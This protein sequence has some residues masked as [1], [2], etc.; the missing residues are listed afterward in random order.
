MS[1]YI[2]LIVS[3]M[4][5]VS[6]KNSTPHIS[7]KSTTE[8]YFGKSII[9]SYRNLENLEDTIVL[10]YIKDYNK[11]STDQLSKIPNKERL[12]RLQNDFEKTKS[13]SYKDILYLK[14]YIFY[15]KRSV[16]ENEYKLYYK[17]PYENIKEVILFDPTNFELSKEQDFKITYFKPSWDCTKVLISLTKQGSEF[18]KMIVLDIKSNTVLPG[19]ITHSSPT[20]VGGVKWLP[21]NSGFVYNRFSDTLSNKGTYLN[22]KSVLYKLGEKTNKFKDLLS[23]DNNPELNINQ[24]E[25]PE[26]QIEENGKYAIGT[27]RAAGTY[28]ETYFL[29]IKDITTNNW[30]PLF[31]R[32]DKIRD[33][34]QIGDSLIYRTSKNSPNFKI[35]K[36]SFLNPDFEDPKVLVEE[37]KDRVIQ[38]YLIVNNQLFFTTIKNGVE[39]KMYSKKDDN[40]EVEI[41]LPFPSGKV[42]L[43]KTNNPNLLSVIIQGWTAPKVRYIYNTITGK[44]ELDKNYPASMKANFS[45]LIVE[46]VLVKSSDGEEIPLSLVYKKGLKK[47]S[48]T[49]VLMRAY[50]SYGISMT[51]NFYYGF[52]LWAQEGGIYAVAHVRGGGEKGDSWH[53]AGYKNTKSNSWKDL[54]SCSEYLIDNKYT[55]PEKLAL[56]SGSAGGIVLGRAITERPDLFSSAVIDRGLLNP[57]RMESGINGSNNIKEFGSIQ[58]S[59]DFKGLLAMDSYHH[60]KDNVEYPSV[61]ITAGMNDTRLSPWHSI[62]FATKLKEANISNRPILLKAEFESG[63]GMTFSKKDEEFNMVAEVLSYA[64]WQTG[65]PD[66]QPK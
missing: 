21:D 7:Q 20:F 51:P 34:L 9:D 33:F 29:N 17:N 41:K 11:Y 19:F 49:P 40:S 44:F 12:L 35:C 64:F 42:Y 43:S 54:I 38:E 13:A 22:N 16:D 55:S 8:K 46:E 50:G 61:L 23:I 58:D 18:S 63:H 2:I 26:I 30:N 48:S 37:K 57:L 5:I 25:F 56:W 14:D 36:T 4:M 59:L 1:K 15:L 6:C 24:N 27:I 62:K 3:I 39:A 47:D 65:H 45:D 32:S 60:I 10:N 28:H 53:K 52:L 31:K 66:Y